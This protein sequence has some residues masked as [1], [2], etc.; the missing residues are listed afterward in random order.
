MITN[1]TK[2]ISFASSEFFAAVLLRTQFFRS[3]DA[4]SLGNETRYEARYCP[5]FQAS[6][7]HFLDVL[8]PEDE[9]NTRPSNGISLLTDAVIIP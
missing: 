3:Y 4:L 2:S 6:K 9:D 8:I 5:H 7:C 1:A